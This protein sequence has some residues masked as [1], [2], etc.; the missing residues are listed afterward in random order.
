MLALG[1]G[2]VGIVE[3]L[4]VLVLGLLV[5]AVKLAILFLV[6]YAAVRVAQGSSPRD[7]V[8]QFNTRLDRT[9]GRTSR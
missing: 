6:V 9:L 8:E 3:L 7:L 4:I 1:L 5:F 2:S